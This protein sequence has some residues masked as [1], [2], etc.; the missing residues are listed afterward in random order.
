MWRTLTPGLAL[1]LSF[2]G[3]KESLRPRIAAQL[4]FTVQPT[5]ATGGAPITP[6]VTVTVQDVEGNTVTSATASITLAIGTNA[7]G[8]TLSGTVTVAAVGGGATFSNLSIDK[9]GTGYT[10]TAAAAGLTGATSAT[11]DV[12]AGAAA[13]LAFSVQPTGATAGTAISPAVTVMVQ[14]G[15]G[16]TVTSATTSITLTIGTN[17]G[18]GALSGTATVAAVGG[19]ATF[20]NLSIDRAG[21]GYTLNAA[22]TG[23]T[24]ATSATF[25]VAGAAVKLAFTVQPTC[26]TAGAAITPA[27]RV[28]VQD[29]G[30]NTVTKATTSI[31]L[32]IGT[33]AGGGTLSGTATVAAV[34][35]VATFSNL[36]IDKTGTGYTL[37]AAATGLTGATSATFNVTGAAVKLAF[38]VQP[39]GATAGAA[40]TPAVK[41]TVQDAGGNT[42]TSA[43]TSIA[44]AI[45][46]N[47]G[48][49]TLS[50]TATVA[51]VGGVATFSNLS[52]DKP[53]T[54]YTLTAAA[55]GLTVAISAS[56]TVTGAATGAAAQLAFTVQPTSGETAGAAI[57]PAVAVT[58]LDVRGNTVTNASTSITLA[59]G[60]NFGG[61]TLSGTTTVAAVNGVATF[62]NL[63]IDKPGTG[64]TLTAAATGLTG[65]TSTTFNVTS[66]AAKLAFT[67]QPTNIFAGVAITPAVAVTVQDAGGNTVTSTTSITLAIGTNPGG[68]TLS[69]TA[70]A[71]AVGGV[72]TFSNLSIDQ[73]GAGY[74]L[75]AAATG[76]AG[77]TSMPFG[78]LPLVQFVAASAGSEFTCALT[79][80]GGAYCWGSNWL[81]QLGTGTV[82]LGG[83]VPQAVQGSLRFSVI[84]ASGASSGQDFA[85]GLTVSGAAYCWGSNGSG[86]LGIG[87]PVNASAPMPVAGGLQFTTLAVGGAHAC[88]L[89]AAGLAYCWGANGYGQLGTGNG[90]SSSAPV[91]V[92]GG[93]LF[94]SLSAGGGHT[95]AVTAAGAAYCWGSNG[96]GQ[97]GDGTASVLSATPVPVA[98]GA[99]F[100]SV[101]A[102]AVHTCGVT[103]GG[104]GFCWGDNSSG[105]L[106]AGLTG[107][108]SA[109]PVAVVGSLTFTTIVA[110]YT[111]TCGIAVGGAAHCWGD[112]GSGQLGTGAYVGSP[113]PMPVAGGLAFTSLTA[114]GDLIFGGSSSWGSSSYV[115][116][117][118]CGV[119]TG[120]LYC[121]G[122]NAYGKLG[123]PVNSVVPVKVVG[124][125]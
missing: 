69:G 36:S 49:G 38:S 31:T 71:A 39:T 32:A 92:V 72:A 61:G 64:Y 90:Q 17:P 46:T 66:A 125:P 26:A 83:Y 120:G 105:Q 14:D 28:T 109:V 70:T 7:G 2:A 80:A 98:G 78:V 27:V 68:G 96:Y 62:S 24:G 4:A 65:A 21:A 55:T 88:G 60:T 123:S 110:G 51:A 8:G 94:V 84:S 45:G 52:I 112:N 34:N 100:A 74:T 57:T 101:S 5:N 37:T 56:F 59:I 115:V 116:A 99:T 107:G 18:G 25:D 44:V 40:I 93:L 12:T 13:K 121:W 76:L 43:T 16:N 22:A 35:G 9:L 33:N 91:R 10:L 89:T 50:G 23:L 103:T 42:V 85:C 122:D 19:V 1:L 86:Q 118:T 41:V 102:G 117:H 81:G 15:G 111:Q 124:Q 77:A 114:G 97:L 54:G 20:S 29:A 47:F 106:G 3:C 82:S 63:S 48:G 53:G 11:F 6:A 73:A 30:G 87:G 67:V 79:M 95:C 108:Q 119:T 58:V 113:S 75:S 104:A